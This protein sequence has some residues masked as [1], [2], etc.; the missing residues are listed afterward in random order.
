VHKLSDVRD[1]RAPGAPAE[2]GRGPRLPGA[3]SKGG[4]GAEPDVYTAARIRGLRKAAEKRGL[5]PSV[6]FNNVEPAHRLRLQCQRGSV[7]G[8]GATPGLDAPLRQN[9]PGHG[10]R[11]G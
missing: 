9:R 6:W 4:G 1:G 3:V 10:D 8:R 2:A 7:L 5:D 11:I